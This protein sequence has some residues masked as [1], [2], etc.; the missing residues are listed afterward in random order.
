MAFSEKE[1]QDIL[2]QALDPNKVYLYCAGHSYFG[3]SKSGKP[4]RP[5]N[6]CAKCWEVYYWHDLASAP[7]HMRE[8][9]LSELEEV[10]SNMVQMINAGTWDFVP[11]EHAQIEITQ[12]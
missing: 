3:P 12:E 9:R 5:T 8:Q 11:Y 10:L 1:K 7:P 4:I 2:A 6:G